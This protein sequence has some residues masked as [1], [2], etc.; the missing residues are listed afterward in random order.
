MGQV[1]RLWI[2][3]AAGRLEAAFRGASP[4]RGLAVLAHPHPKLGGTLHN[5]VVFHCDRE[6]NA[7]GFAT[8]RFQFRG[9]GSSEGVHDD[10]RGEVE[11]VRAAACWLRE[12]APDAPLLL[13][14]YSFGAVCSLR[15]A[16]AHDVD[17]II[18]IGLPV[19]THGAGE[20][21]R[22]RCPLVVVQGD[23][24]ELASPDDVRRMLA[25]AGVRATLRVIGGAAHR[26]TG[27]AADVARV[28]VE[29]A[30]ELVVS[31]SGAAPAGSVREPPLPR[32]E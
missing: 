26:F 3:G 8:L 6:L 25:D 20:I 17:G 16:A 31:R 22:L 28:V 9:V 13:V 24:D 27:R 29:A 18:A 12:V 21:G 7:A 14:G 4:A 1:R 32:R 19:R 2:E 5:P 11:D 10:G 15:L 23:E 30:S